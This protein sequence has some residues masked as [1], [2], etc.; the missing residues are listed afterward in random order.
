MSSPFRRTRLVQ[1][2]AGI[3]LISSAALICTFLAAFFTFVPG[4]AVAQQQA[5]STLP[6]VRVTGE[7][8]T[9]NDKLP[10]EAVSS[11]GSR[12]GITTRENPSSITVV[13]R[14]TIE[15]RGARDTQEVLRGTPGVVASAPPGSGGF[16][17]MRGFTG[18]QITQ[19]FNGISVQYDAVAA[20]PVDSWLYERVE[21][22]GGASSFLHGSGAVGGAVNY[23]TKLASRQAMQQDVFASYG[24]YNSSQLAYGLNGAVNA[25]NYLRLDISRQD[26]EGWVE[27]SPA[28]S[29][30][31]AASW[32]TDISP[33]FSHTLAVE[34]QHKSQRP[35]WGTP[36]LNPVT[37]GQIDPATRFKNYN[38]DNGQYQQDIRWVRSITDYRLGEKSKLTNTA[39][40]YDAERVYRDVEV[41]TWNATNTAINRL[42]SGVLAQKHGQTMYGN[43]T[44]LTHEGTLASLPTQWAAGLDLSRNQQ[45]RYPTSLSA[46]PTNIDVV[47]PYNPV[48]GD[49]YSIPGA[50]TATN[51]DR[52]NR[53]YTTSAYLENRTRLTNALSLVS[54]LRF[55]DIRLDV[56]NYRAV[57]ATN[58]AYFK[59]SFNAQT[60]RIGVVYDLT[61]TANLY[62]NYSTSAD[63]PAGILTTL[64]F[65]SVLDFGL[66]TGRQFEVGS[67]FDFWQGRGNATVAAYRVERE[68]LSITDPNNLLN[69]L[70]VGAQSTRG[71]EM[72]AGV[73]LGPQWRVQG[74]LSV[75]AARY[76]SFT[77][78]VGA[79]VISRVGYVPV[80]VPSRVANLWVTYAFAPQWEAGLG[81]RGVSSAYAS[82]DNTVRAAGY[83]LVDAS[84]S[85]RI[86]KNM[87]VTARARNLGDKVYAE[88]TT[89]TPLFYLG[90][91]R[92]F[93][94]SFRGTF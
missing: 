18:S 87:S 85:Y 39:Y 80:N 11:T 17:S 51:P 47:D 89:T 67:K 71:I 79:T 25:N 63:P 61:P 38:S 52:T 2:L 91:P 7:R 58:P 28:R 31:A 92:S 81:L 35:Y 94:V 77:Q 55:D 93:D 88:T 37:S 53:V 43:K 68:N 49:F 24:R 66:T 40:W 69:T 44:E 42:R 73:R 9:P 50:S 48:G 6:E 62:A 57:S 26:T 33:G 60:G 45:T 83:G 76:D 20:Y 4:R 59:R 15:A 74:N 84:L 12:L 29:T 41:Y 19:M 16:V 8:D 75:L 30:V 36:L 10:L 14:E 27:R 23:I 72:A 21:V 54:G 86:A 70:P 82:V 46:P 1:A 13:D 65:A 90:A 5:D 3:H 34:Y 64:N 32:L 56:T 78:T 22:L